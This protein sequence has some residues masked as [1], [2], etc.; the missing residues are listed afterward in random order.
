MSCI[1]VTGSE[2]LIGKSLCSFLKSIGRDVRHCDIIFSE[3]HSDFADILNLENIE[4]KI[5][6]C[7]G[8]VHL[9][10][11]SRVVWGEKNPKLCW[12]TNVDGTKNIINSAKN[13]PL[14]P[15]I[16]YASSREIYG[17][18]EKFPVEIDTPYAPLNIYARSKVAAE[19][20]IL[21]ARK[22]G[23]NTAVV[24]YSS[25]YGS[26]H[27]HVD[28]VVPAFCR[29]A[30]FGEQVRIDGLKNIL[31]FTHINDVVDGTL[32][33][34]DLLESGENDLPPLHLTTGV[35]TTLK[36]L[37]ELAYESSENELSFIETPSRS[38]DVSRFWGSTTKAFELLNWKA[39][40]SVRD[41]VYGLVKEY[42]NIFQDKL[43]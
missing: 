24:R 17:Q 2:G 6:D 18:Q 13:S 9:A 16:I 40:I 20:E 22:F 10:A 38:Y 32:K 29:S 37:A 36:E 26:T 42:K 39:K 5:K 41:G 14:K 33:L 25:V 34:I 12:S 28:R 1:L 15:W 23:L 21:N 11:V 7:I 31:D 30:V 43:I 3:G 4:K 35:P 19:K 27:D 8:I